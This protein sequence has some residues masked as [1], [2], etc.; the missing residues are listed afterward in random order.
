MLQSLDYQYIL[1]FLECETFCDSVSLR[2]DSGIIHRLSLD[3]RKTVSKKW[4]SLTGATVRPSKENEK[5][6][7]GL[8]G[9]RFRLGKS[10]SLTELGKPHDLVL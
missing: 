4:V 7:V 6:R 9:T 3:S 5:S 10:L 2:R 8:T 1:L